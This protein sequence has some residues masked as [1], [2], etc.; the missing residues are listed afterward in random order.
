MRLCHLQVKD[1][2]ILKWSCCEVVKKKSFVLSS[3]SWG[4]V[5]ETHINNN[6]HLHC[7]PSCWHHVCGGLLQNK[8]IPFSI[9]ILMTALCEFYEWFKYWHGKHWDVALNRS[10][11]VRWAENRDKSCMIAWGRVYESVMPWLTWA[12]AHSMPKTSS[13]HRKACSFLT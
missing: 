4:A 13:N 7:S 12:M 11:F 9:D 3:R 8:V 6:R 1:S 2:L 5:S 10:V